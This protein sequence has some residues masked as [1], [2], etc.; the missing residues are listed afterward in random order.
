MTTIVL[1]F[2]GASVASV[3]QFKTLVEIIRQEKERGQK[4]VVVISAM[5]DTTDN[6]LALARR[7]NPHPPLREQDM[8][9]SVGERISMALLAMSLAAEGLEA[10]SFTG[11][12]SGIITT[13]GHANARIVN[14][15]PFRLLKALEEGKIVIVAGFQGVST[16]GEITTLGRGGSDT[17]AVV[18][19]AALQAEMVKF[20]KDVP[21]I[22]SS[23]PKVDPNASFLPTLS[24]E[25]AITLTAKG[26]Q[27]IHP[28]AVH[29][30]CK[31]A[32]TLYFTSFDPEQRMRYPGTWIKEEKTK[33]SPDPFL[34]IAEDSSLLAP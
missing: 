12:Q 15:K 34:S 26:A 7:V 27:V 16:Q 10:I 24:Y 6:L 11:S 18:L 13:S 1:K 20:Y 22:F 32:I 30:A 31:Y 14:V 23:D 8:L 28:R 25:E 3:E 33:I 21:G 5:G 17:T 4:I 19:A 29:L 9:L 2:G